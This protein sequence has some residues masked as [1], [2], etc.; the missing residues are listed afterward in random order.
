MLIVGK[1]NQDVLLLIE[2]IQ[3][4]E[5]RVVYI[6]LEDQQIRAQDKVLARRVWATLHMMT[7]FSPI[8]QPMH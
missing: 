7:K 3:E 6:V 1:V 8:G 4:L 5:L 2:Q